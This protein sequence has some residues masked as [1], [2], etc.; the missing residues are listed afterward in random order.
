MAQLSSAAGS[1]PCFAPTSHGIDPA[2]QNNFAIKMAA[3]KGHLHMLKYFMEGVNARFKFDAAAENNYAI[4]NAAL[5]GHVE[6]VKYLIEEVGTKHGIDPAARDNYAIVYA[7]YNGHLNVVI[8][9]T[10]ISAYGMMGIT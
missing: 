9:W 1:I 5:S 2:A 8:E 6:V 7:A 4:R 10:S 3:P